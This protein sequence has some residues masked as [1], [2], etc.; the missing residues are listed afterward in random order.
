ME[1]IYTKVIHHEPIPV[2][3]IN[4]NE[5]KPM[6]NPITY[7]LLNPELWEDGI[8]LFPNL[9]DEKLP[10]N[11]VIE[12]K[13]KKVIKVYKSENMIKEKVIESNENHQSIITEPLSKIKVKK[14]YHNNELHS[15][16]T[17]KIRNFV[18]NMLEFDTT[19][20]ILCEKK[21]QKGFGVLSDNGHEN[22]FK[23][24]TIIIEENKS[25]E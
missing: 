11:M 24:F 23:R 20:F 9:M 18:G 7:E 16:L 17:A 13:N 10:I 5:P 1:E 15:E 3:D 2:K 12:V 25:Y 19:P 8:H 14:S 21:N 4:F 6:F 22:M